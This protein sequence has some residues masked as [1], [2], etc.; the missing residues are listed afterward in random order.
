M[1]NMTKLDTQ[2]QSDL[3][4]NSAALCFEPCAD[5]CQ[6]VQT[7]SEVSKRFLR[8]AALLP[9]GEYLG[10]Q[11]DLTEERP[12]TGAVFSS[13]NA[14]AVSE[15]Y[16]WLFRQ[17][18]KISS[19]PA[20]DLKDLYSG[21]RKVYRLSSG[22]RN[23]DG[24]DPKAYDD[25]DPDDGLFEMLHKTGAVI[26][27]VAGAL[28][29]NGFE[30][31]KTDSGHAAVYIS[32][33]EE[34]SLRVR[35]ALS[36]TFPHTAIEEAG[37]ACGP[38]E[39]DRL[40][41][42]C[43][44]NVMR[45]LLCALTICS[46]ESTDAEDE[47]LT[48]SIPIDELELSVRA[49]NCLRH[50][51]ICTVGELRQMSDDEIRNLRNMGSKAYGEIKK[52]LCERTYEKKAEKGAVPPQTADYT[53]MLEKLIGLKDVK[54]QVRRITAFAKMKQSMQAKGIASVPV[55]L[56]M[57]FVGNP[58]TAKTTVARIV[59]GIFY[60][61][62]LLAENELIEVGRS[63]LVAEYEGQTAV[64]VKNV[65]E[66][67]KGKV[68]FIDEAYSLAEGLHGAYG[69]EAVNTIVQEMENHREDTIV[70]FAGYPDKMEEFFDRN[71]GLRSRVPFK[72]SF[73]DYS[74]EEMVKITESEAEKR[75]FAI[76]GEA[77]NK[78]TAVLSEA[79]KY[80]NLG[81]GR[82]CRNL[83][84]DA[85]LSFAARIY[86]CKSSQPIE[87]DFLLLADDFGTPAFLDEEAKKLPIGF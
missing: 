80:P 18:A 41:D 40:P 12:Y 52:V 32:L 66:R 58:G 23:V 5:R 37:G 57:E 4:A 55:T 7:A 64:K 16:I 43:F 86:G 83:I 62:G 39:T 2:L 33:P 27:I 1:A 26:R 70:I 9:A 38:C 78:I 76:S 44:R 71:P 56:N 21:G 87:T 34:I 49:Y 74:V 42:S 17:C 25:G 8:T 84:E 50:A 68:L 13:I 79:S 60:E 47:P 53:A 61:T 20:A 45:K 36:Y 46:E 28:A 77:Y 15:D 10:L 11:I 75:G 82:F 19:S 72:I 48:A 63:G 73:S 30:S 85:V 24:L 22:G 14:S 67:A 3:I 51:G 6:G 69:D 35:S 54:D 81:N 59:T 65:F 29:E 31:V